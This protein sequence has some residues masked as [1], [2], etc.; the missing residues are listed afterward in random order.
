MRKNGMQNLVHKGGR[1][2]SYMDSRFPYS[3]PNQITS[4]LAQIKYIKST[5]IKFINF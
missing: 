2:Q 1:V 4:D 3:N 5:L